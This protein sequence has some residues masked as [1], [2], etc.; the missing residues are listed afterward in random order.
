MRKVV[1]ILVTG[2]GGFIGRNI[3]E[4]LRDK[5]EI[6]SPSRAELDLLDFYC[7]E[8]YLC[9]YKFDV[10]IHTATTNLSHHKEMNAFDLF[11]GNLRMFYNLEHFSQ[12]YGK[13]IYLGSGAEYSMDHYEPNMSEEFFGKYIPEDSYGF[14]KYIMAKSALNSKNIYDLVLFGVYGKYEEQDRRFISNNICKNL[15]GKPMTLTQ[16]VYFDY[17]Y[18]D[19]FIQILM[20][21]IEN[22]PKYKRYNVCRGEKIDLLTLAKTINKIMKTDTEIQIAQSGYK[23]EYTGDNTRMQNEVKYNKFETYESSIVKLIQFYKEQMAIF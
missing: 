16:N 17:L 13:M 6:F 4:Q 18:I 1:K 3:I 8:R 15:S 2:S 14:S 20:Y 11:N 21:F 12:Y 10:I 22:E 9:D 7:V 23:R 5:Y 19:D